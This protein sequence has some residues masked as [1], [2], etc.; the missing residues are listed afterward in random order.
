M[1]TAPWNPDD[2][3]D[4]STLLQEAGID[5]RE[6]SRQRYRQQQW[7]APCLSNRIPDRTKFRAVQCHDLSPQGIAFDFPE[8]LDEEH[9][10]IALVTGKGLVYA[11]ARVA[12]CRLVADNDKIYR[13]GCQFLARIG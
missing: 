7:I 8:P 9:L 11:K 1:K 3:S 12:H 13:I 2:E 10:V 5:R 4:F 6:R